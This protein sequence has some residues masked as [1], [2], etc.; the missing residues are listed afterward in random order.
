MAVGLGIAGVVVLSGIIVI[1]CHAVQK[2]E[3]ERKEW[4]EFVEE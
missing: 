1:F 2:I 4:R 3:Q